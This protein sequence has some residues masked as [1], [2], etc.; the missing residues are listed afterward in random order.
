MRLP[1]LDRLRR[2]VD[3]LDERDRR[4]LGW[5]GATA[6]AILVAGGLWQAQSSVARMRE[7]VERKRL[8]LAFMQ[9]ASAEIVA[10]GPTRAFSTEEPLLV[11]VDRAARESGLAGAIGASETVPPNALRI[12]LGGASF[13]AVVAMT[14]RLAQQHGVSVVAAS[15]ER[16]A[17]SGTVNATLTLRAATP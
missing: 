8:D 12:R 1:L 10:A 6:L 5:G 13:D 2:R 16:A 15:I 17:Q 7:A 3:G 4:V 14:S 11:I 9:A